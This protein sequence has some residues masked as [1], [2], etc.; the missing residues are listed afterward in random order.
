MSVSKAGG[1]IEPVESAPER[2]SLHIILLPPPI[3]V[4]ISAKSGV[5]QL[6]AGLG[7]NQD[8]SDAINA[9]RA[10][11]EVLYQVSLTTDD[12]VAANPSELEDPLAP[13]YEEQLN[14]CISLTEDQG[15]AALLELRTLGRGLRA[16]LDKGFVDELKK[17]G[18][19]QEDPSK[20]PSL[21]FSTD[22]KASLCWEM[23]YEERTQK[24]DW[25]NFW[26]FRVPITHSQ[27]GQ[28]ETR[29]RLKKGLFSAVDQTLTF[30]D[31]EVVLLARQLGS[32]LQHETL[33][34]QIKAR[35]REELRCQMNKDDTEL[36]D[37]FTARGSEAWLSSF[38][39]ELFGEE[40]RGRT[41]EWKEDTIRAVFSP[42]Q[43]AFELVHFACHCEPSNVT[44]LLTALKVHIGGEDV[45]LN[46]AAMAD[47][48][49]AWGLE[50]PGP[51]VFLNACGTGQQ[52][53]TAE[54]PGFPETWMK[55]H[56]AL[57]VIATMCPVPDLFAH[58]FALKFYNLLFQCEADA[59]P[60]YVGEV[61]L[62]TR[63]YF[64]EHC[65]NPLGL[66]YVLYAFKDASVE[67]AN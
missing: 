57:A 27:V 29:I 13:D 4:L 16:R 60:R 63:R 49:H 25:K 22:K 38:F 1:Y 35:V 64:M 32:V 19:P 17:L 41:L 14:S 51:L 33:N 43:F 62:E 50:E 44:E 40:A 55:Q 7:F 56:G 66:A 20:E 15:L 54:P 30:A 2:R 47:N 3:P 5:S 23:M 34:N 6:P 11:A 31:R 36:D 52:G 45:S 8:D 10:F 48:D 9:K 28:R 24:V 18:F 39:A 58:A 37:W 59:R 12:N 53:Q 26:G 61:L 67:T 21:T 46:V 42:R 65:R